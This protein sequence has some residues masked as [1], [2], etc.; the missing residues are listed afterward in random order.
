MATTAVVAFDSTLGEA[1]FTYTGKVLLPDEK[2]K[3]TTPLALAAAKGRSTDA[4]TFEKFTLYC[5]FFRQELTENR[6]NNIGIR[7]VHRTFVIDLI[8]FSI[9]F[10]F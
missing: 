3:G 5:P 1:I 4:P 10:I 2:E 6:M 9:I 8:F 7:P